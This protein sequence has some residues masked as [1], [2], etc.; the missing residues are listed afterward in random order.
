MGFRK[1][2]KR[3]LPPCPDPERYVVVK[4]DEGYYWRRKRGTVRKATV[5]EAFARNAETAKITRPA[6]VR[7]FNKLEP[8]I[9]GLKMGKKHMTI[10]GLFMKTYNKNGVIDFSM[11]KGQEL[12]DANTLDKIFHG[13]YKAEI[14]HDHVQVMLQFKNGT[15]KRQNTLVTDYYF[16]VVLVSGDLT[17]D[18][19]LFVEGESSELFAFGQKKLS[20]CKLELPLPRKKIPWMLL[21]KVNCHE[22]NELAYH[23]KNYAMK[24]VAVGGGE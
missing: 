23:P 19:K 12:N 6:T 4:T 18:K 7:L 5:N 3:Q 16:E 17:K 22:G 20:D 8:F 1:Y 10:A 13:E 14:Q 21:L 9:R 24:V 11:L 2:S 15:V